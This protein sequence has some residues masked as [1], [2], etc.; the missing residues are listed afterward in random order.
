MQPLLCKRNLLVVDLLGKQAVVVHFRS[1]RVIHLF[2]NI[3]PTAY[4]CDIYLTKTVSKL[5]TKIR[6]FLV[7][8]LFRQNFEKKVCIT[9]FITKGYRIPIVKPFQEK[10]ECFSTR[11]YSNNSIDLLFCAAIL[12]LLFTSALHKN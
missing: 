8:F 12:F 1:N 6:Y 3:S 9:I 5:S 10:F 7:R 11:I 4:N 2:Y